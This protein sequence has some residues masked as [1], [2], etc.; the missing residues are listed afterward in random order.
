LCTSGEVCRGGNCVNEQ[1]SADP[2]KTTD[3]VAAA[4]QPTDPAL[5]GTGTWAIVRAEW[6]ADVPSLTGLSP[7]LAAVIAAAP[8][9]AGGVVVTLAATAA[10]GTV[11]GW[12]ETVEIECQ[13]ATASLAPVPGADSCAQNLLAGY[14]DT[15]A[16][17]VAPLDAAALLGEASG[18][19]IATVAHPTSPDL[20]QTLPGTPAIEV[21]YAEGAV[22]GLVTFAGDDTARAAALGKDLIARLSTG[23]TPGNGLVGQLAFAQGTAPVVDV[24]YS[25]LGGQSQRLFGETDAQ[26]T[27]QQATDGKATDFARATQLLPTV[28]TGTDYRLSTWASYFKSSKAARNWLDGTDQRLATQNPD[29]KLVSINEA[30]GLG[31][32]SKGVLYTLDLADGK[33]VG[34]T[35]YVSRGATVFTVGLSASAPQLTAGLSALFAVPQPLGTGAQTVL[36]TMLAAPS[37][38]SP[39]G[40]RPVPVADV[41]AGSPLGVATTGNRSVATMTPTSEEKATATRTPKKTATATPTPE[42]TATITPTSETGTDNTSSTASNLK[43]TPVPDLAWIAPFPVRDVPNSYQLAGGTFYFGLDAAKRFNGLPA[44]YA[45]WVAPN[46]TFLLFNQR[47]QVPAANGAQPPRSQFDAN[48]FWFGTSASAKQ[49]KANF[50]AGFGNATPIDTTAKNWNLFGY[51]GTQNG[52][53]FDAVAGV[54]T[55]RNY[56][57]FVQ[58]T[59]YGVSVDRSGWDIYLA[60]VA[61]YLDD[62]RTGKTPNLGQFVLNP[63]GDPSTSDLFFGNYFVIDGTYARTVGQTDDQYAKQQTRNKQVAVAYQGGF[64]SANGLVGTTLRRFG[65]AGDAKTY[66]DVVTGTGRQD[67]TAAGFVPMPLG[68]LAVPQDGIA[69]NSLFGTTKDGVPTVSI[70][71]DDPA[72]T[73]V[74]GLSLDDLSFKVPKG[75]TLTSGYTDAVRAGVTRW[76]D[77]EDAVL[78]QG[79]RKLATRPQPP[80]PLALFPEFEGLDKTCKTDPTQCVK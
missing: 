64:F 9:L 59:D 46:A 27:A 32:A 77:D 76:I 1:A 74:V 29:A 2:A 16:A 58:Q 43:V 78:H 67:A 34:V 54:Y 47:L 48:I 39:F 69:V 71:I 26:F 57:L 40:L 3:L 73:L 10:D 12:A 61:G 11:T 75:V 37:G 22:F 70:D 21:T 19:R 42:E 17:K 18:A 31:D 49:T 80:P 36:K 20:I 66:F 60:K 38:S 51:G 23:T 5:N 4:V 45:D 14:V 15:T 28:E 68:D 65:G 52:A 25:R 62:A 41:F 50:V 8:G 56:F 33:A 72:N 6:T 7:E 53:A 24:Y 55:T 13:S 79:A 44:S 35:L 63:Y 30:D